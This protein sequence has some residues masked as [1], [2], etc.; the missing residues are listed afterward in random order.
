[1]SQNYIVTNDG[2]NPK[3]GVIVTIANKTFELT[4]VPK[5]HTLVSAGVVTFKQ[6]HTSVEADVTHGRI[7]LGIAHDANQIPIDKQLIEKLFL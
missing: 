1:M 7:H 5:G 4:D 3:E 2:N 6:G